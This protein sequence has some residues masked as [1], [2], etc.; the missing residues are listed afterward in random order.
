MNI[1]EVNQEFDLHAHYES[2]SHDRLVERCVWLEHEKTALA[3]VNES[4][5]RQV[6]FYQAR[7]TF[8]IP[9]PANLARRASASCPTGKEPLTVAGQSPTSGFH[10]AESTATDAILKGHYPILERVPTIGGL[11]SLLAIIGISVASIVW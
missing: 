9:G 6:A 1:V 2:M 5:R 8:G 4:L 3:T 10:V 11:L 7:Q